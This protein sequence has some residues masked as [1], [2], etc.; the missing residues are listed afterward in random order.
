MLLEYQQYVLAYRLRRALG[1]ALSPAEAQLSLAAYGLARNERQ[2][3]ARQM[4]SRACPPGT[5]MRLETLTDKLLFGFWHNPAQMADFLRAAIRQGG[6]PALERPDAF[7]ALLSE[8][9][10]R[11]LGVLGVRQVI[12]HHHACL[13]LAAFQNHPHGLDAAWAC[14]E[15]ERVPLFID[16]LSSPGSGG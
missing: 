4:I 10:Q 8:A 6:H 5:L 2:A 14:I 7:A 9:E 3:L 11:R 15:A 13:A 16:E 1:G 12:R